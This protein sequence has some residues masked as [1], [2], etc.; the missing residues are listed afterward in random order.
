MHERPG[1]RRWWEASGRPAP[2]FVVDFGCG[3]GAAGPDLAAAFPGAEV[4]GI[5]PSAELIERART[6]YPEQRFSTDLAP[7][8]GRAALVHVNGVVHHVSPE[9]RPDFYAQVR[10]L[11]QPG[12]VAAIFENNPLNPGTRLVMRRIPFDRDAQPLTHWRLRRD[13]S[14]AGLQPLHWASLFYFPR[15]LRLLRPLERGLHRLPLG[16]QYGVFAL[17]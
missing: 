16:A 17:R 11:L 2:G 1:P 13:L 14:Q 6:S 8:L 15:P 5:D 9:D 12:G 3:D 7:F 10:D 4:A